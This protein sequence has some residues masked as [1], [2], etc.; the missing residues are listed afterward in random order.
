MLGQHELR[1]RLVRRVCSHVREQA[2]VLRAEH[3]IELGLAL[4][5]DGPESQH[6]DGH[7]PRLGVGGQDV[8][9]I[10]CDAGPFVH[11]RRMVVPATGGVS[12]GKPQSP[13]EVRAGFGKPG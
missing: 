12:R 8:G 4:L 6:A 13:V 2:G 11:G 1:V 7:P 3:I 10:G 5:G 9:V